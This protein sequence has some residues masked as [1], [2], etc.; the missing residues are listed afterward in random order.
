MIAALTLLAC[1]GTPPEPRPP[2]PVDVPEVVPEPEPEP[3]PISLTVP[4]EPAHAAAALALAE[5]TVRDPA[6]S[7]EVIAQHGHLQQR[8]YRLLASDKVMARATVAALPEEWREVAQ[9]NVDATYEIARTVK[10]LRSDLPPW[11]IIDPEPAETLMAEYK[12]AEA[13][14]GVPWQ[15]L[16]G[17]HLVETRLG[18]LSGT[19]HAGAAGPMQFM[20]GTWD[21]YGEGDINDTHDA[22]F[23][24][25]RYLEAM[26][27]PGDLKK[28]LWHYNH[29]DHY[30][31]SVLG[32][33]SVMDKDPRAFHG[34][35]GWQVY[36][37]TVFG[38][39]WLETGY[40]RTERGP[41]PEYCAERGEPACPTIHDE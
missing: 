8:I 41:I 5:Q 38:D 4:S 21:A 26:G 35:H 29:T 2:E 11:R 3:E 19:S 39:I 7:A 9:A 12:A 27:A 10:K 25:G 28:A 23:A 17:V 16:A 36:Y 14:F 34:Y 32:Y 31:N 18:R 40:A 20:P 13:E 22:I 1:A 33:A 6:A 24:A 30:G 15:V 37:R